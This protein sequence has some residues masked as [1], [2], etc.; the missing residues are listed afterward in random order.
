MNK[1]PELDKFISSFLD[2]NDPRNRTDRDRKISRSALR[3]SV[4]K[5]FETLDFSKLRNNK[6]EIIDLVS[7]NFETDEEGLQQL[8]QTS[9]SK[10]RESLFNYLRVREIRPC[11][12]K[13]PGIWPFCKSDC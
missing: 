13:Y 12:S 1:K 10:L 3:L 6:Q 7:N 5:R 8:T 11:C 9:E 4:Y 2:S